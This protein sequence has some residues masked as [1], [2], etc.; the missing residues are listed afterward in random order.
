MIPNRRTAQQGK[1]ADRDGRLANDMKES[2]LCFG[3]DVL[4]SLACCSRLPLFSGKPEPPGANGC[5]LWASSW[6][7]TGWCFAVIVSSSGQELW[8]LKPRDS[9]RPFP[10]WLFFPLKALDLAE[11]KDRSGCAQVGDFQVGF[12]CP[13][14]KRAALAGWETKEGGPAIGGKSHQ[15]ETHDV[16]F[17]GS[18]PPDSVQLEPPLISSNSSQN[19]RAST[20]TTGTQSEPDNE[21]LIANSSHHGTGQAWTTNEEDDG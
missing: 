13:R 3:V 2:G 4:V 7:A 11:R 18:T 17:R 10:A 20:E 21:W 5:K 9:T 15:G 12:C 1:E 6:R 8:M 19:Y 14:T 16:G